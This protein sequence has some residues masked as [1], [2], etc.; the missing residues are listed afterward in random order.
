MHIYGMIPL[1]EP[2]SLFFRS[3]PTDNDAQY[4]MGCFSRH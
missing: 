4:R 2:L 1:Y 3:M